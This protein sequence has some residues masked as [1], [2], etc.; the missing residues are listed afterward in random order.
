MKPTKLLAL[1]AL[2][3]TALIAAGAALP[4]QDDEGRKAFKDLTQQEQMAA[5]LKAMELAVPGP[6]HELLP[7]R[8]R[9]APGTASTRRF[10]W[11]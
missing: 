6:E 8:A 7:S 11:R 5:Q 3:T 2:A 9:P 1:S 4:G 10:R